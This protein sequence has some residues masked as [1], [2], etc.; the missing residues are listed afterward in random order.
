MFSLQICVPCTLV[1]QNAV[2]SPA[3]TLHV[4]EGCRWQARLSSLTKALGVERFLRDKDVV[5]SASTVILHRGLSS[6]DIKRESASYILTRISEKNTVQ[7]S[8]TIDYKSIQCG[9]FLLS[10]D[11]I[12]YIFTH[13]GN[14]IAK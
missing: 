7:A 6:V 2:W 11:T 3:T 13:V 9:Y 4:L 10:L 12:T 1:G 8:N 14:F 5:Q